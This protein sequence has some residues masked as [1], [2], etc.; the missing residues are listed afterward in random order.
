VWK[1]RLLRGLVQRGDYDRAYAIWRQFAGLPASS[2]PLLFNGDFKVVAAPAPFNWTF[3]SGSAGIAEPANG[4]LR[5]LFYGNAEQ[6]LASQLLL[7]KP[8]NY[9]FRAP[10]DG[11]PAPGALSWTVSCGSGGRPIMDV[12]LTSKATGA[13]FAVPADC[14]SQV[15]RLTGHLEDM[16][17]NSDVRIGPIQLERVGA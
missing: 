3:S 13:R 7:L 15:F 16:P 2:S 11:N 4:K 9:E 14:P 8:G 12:P 5:V 10:V 17:Q 1:S 6:A